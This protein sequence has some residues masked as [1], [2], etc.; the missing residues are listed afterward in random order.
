MPTN[1][2]AALDAMTCFNLCHR[3]VREIRRARENKL[4]TM[5][6]QFTGLL[7]KTHH[8]AQEHLRAAHGN[9]R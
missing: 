1:R 6:K 9:H 3:Y 4:P 2:Y 7:H 5:E 8:E